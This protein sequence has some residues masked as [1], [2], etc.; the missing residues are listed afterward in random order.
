[1]IRTP[2]RVVGSAAGLDGAAVATCAGAG[3]AARSRR[4]AGMSGS[5][6]ACIGAGA[7]EVGAAGSATAWAARRRLR[8]RGALVAGVVWGVTCASVGLDFTGTSLL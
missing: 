2:L 1:M 8:A 7:G 5:A 6:A 3:R 4:K